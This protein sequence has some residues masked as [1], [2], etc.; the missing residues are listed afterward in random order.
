MD[1]RHLPHSLNYLLSFD[2]RAQ[3][4][5]T[6]TICLENYSSRRCD[7]YERLIDTNQI[8]S[9]IQ[10]VSNMDENT[11]YT[12]HI[13]NNSFGNR[14]T[15]NLIK[16]ISVHPI[17]LNFIKNISISSPQSL[18]EPG[19]LVSS[20]HPFPFLYTASIENNR[21][22]V[23]N[24]YQTKSSSWKALSVSARDLELPPWF[25]SIITPLVYFFLP[26]LFQTTTNLWHNAWALSEGSSNLIIVYLPQYLQFIGLILLLITPVIILL[27]KRHKKSSTKR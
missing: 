7:V 10:P 6:P 2:L 8:Q 25:I 3:K 13:Y 22:S 16:K 9:V 23:I 20:E 1:L 15:S 11:G 27:L 12:L 4:G 5:L 19:K 24:L 26:N 21:S 18:I 17:P 14:I